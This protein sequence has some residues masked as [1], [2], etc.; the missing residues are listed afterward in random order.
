M[1]LVSDLKETVAD[2]SA[3]VKQ[4]KDQIYEELLLIQK[5]ILKLQN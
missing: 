2:L 1:K 3:Q 4:L 5:I